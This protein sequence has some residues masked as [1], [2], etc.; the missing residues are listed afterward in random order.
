MNERKENGEYVMKKIRWGLLST[1]HINNQLIP[2]IRHSRFGELVAVA[3]RGEE[4][5]RSYAELW[6][7]PL[8]FDSYEAL[9]ASD[10]IDV[11]YIALPNHLHAEWMIRAMRAGKHV[12]CEKPFVLTLAEMDEVTRV[13]EE[14][15]RKIMEG[16]MY[17]YHPQT[18]KVIELISSGAIGEVAGVEGVFSFMLTDQTNIRWNPKFGG[19]ALW[20]IGIYPLSFAQLIMGS[21]PEQVFAQMKLSQSGVDETFFGQMQYSG[22]RFAQIRCSFC[23]PQNTGLN[24]L[25]T[26]GRIEIFRPF[27]SMEKQRKILLVDEKGKE[28]WVAI[29]RFDLYTGEV[30]DLCQAISDDREPMISLDETRNHV[31]TLQAL[32]QSARENRVVEIK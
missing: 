22:S 27:N 3:S 8:H 31:H 23:L 18:Q 25:G 29:P 24:I 21:A 26:T 28:K 17:R 5:A 13:K 15:G 6:Q 14:T 16:F 19:G 32:Y 7:I 12:L 30:D 4:K 11:V 10:E 2:A 1:A 9:L 20:D